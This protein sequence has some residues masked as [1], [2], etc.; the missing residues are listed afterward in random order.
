MPVI[1]AKSHE[2]AAKK[3]AAAVAHNSPIQAAVP[4]ATLAGSPAN[5]HMLT[6][7]MEN[8]LKEYVRLRNEL[9][10]YEKQKDACELHKK[11]LLGN[12]AEVLPNDEQALYTCAYGTVT[13]SPAP[14]AREIT[15]ME[16]LMKTL[17][18]K[19]DYKTMVSCIK[20]SLAEMDKILGEA[21]VEKF[22]TH[23]PGSRKVAGY[24]HVTPPDAL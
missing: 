7:E 4:V 9:E 13:I 24:T 23:K 1:L 2:D 16:G 20:V 3:V 19:T 22:V 8:H 18:E 6:T 14:D 21:T 12:A 5:V 17:K 11:A 10:A 15:D